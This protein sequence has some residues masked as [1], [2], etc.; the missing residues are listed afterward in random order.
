MGCGDL[1]LYRRRI[2]LPVF[3]DGME[4]R[5]FCFVGMGC[6][7]LFLY[8]RRI[9]LPVFPDGMEYRSFPRWRGIKG[10]EPAF[11]SFSTYFSGRP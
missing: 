10:V 2:W 1:H 8:R 4:Y 9:W 3:P 7:D 6:G 5:T 11:F